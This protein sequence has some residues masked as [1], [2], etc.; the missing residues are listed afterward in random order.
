MLLGGLCIEMHHEHKVS[1]SPVP[2]C[3]GDSLHVD[4]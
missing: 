3:F 2:Y 1:Q 4:R